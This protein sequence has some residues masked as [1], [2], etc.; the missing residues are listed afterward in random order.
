MIS[1][2]LSGGK[3]KSNMED[4]DVKAENNMK[5]GKKSKILRELIIIMTM[6]LWYSGNIRCYYMS[7]DRFQVYS[8]SAT[9]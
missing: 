2:M 8:Q 3:Q 9:R 1:L 4:A 7:G 5:D 6:V